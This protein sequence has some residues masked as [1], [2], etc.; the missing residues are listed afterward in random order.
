MNAHDITK[1]LGG[2]W[3]GSFGKVPG[4]GHSSKDRSVKVL[5]GADGEII[6][7][8][9]AADDWRDIKAAWRAQGL[10]PEWER[11][12]HVDPGEKE[13][14]RRQ[15]QERQKQRE[16]QDQA[17]AAKKT[18][19]FMTIWRSARPAKGSVVETYARGRGIT[20]ELPLS[21]RCAGSIKHN[22]TGLFL[23][24]MVAPVQNVAGKIAGGHRTIL[25]SDGRKKA[26]VSQNKMMLGPCAGGAVR[27][28]AAAP[29]LAI[30][31]GIETA[32]SFMQATGIP[33]WAAL[34][35]SGIK[36]IVLPGIVRE[37]VVA[38]DND[39]AGKAAAAV[40]AKRFAT[41]GRTAHIVLPPGDADDFNTALQQNS[42]A[43][44]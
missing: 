40:A 29:K 15:A 35:T 17:E 31:E 26:P 7:H 25:T 44:I 2:D 5:D 4:P 27:L 43:A 41:E 18:E 14:R 32:L 9:F 30:A 34:S 12:E 16:A 23:P 39:D 1:A 36:N 20:I 19:T 37:V 24:A 38:A 21:I 3:L 33:T 28:A 8:G 42:E 11:P 22:P 10:L 13:R 6:V